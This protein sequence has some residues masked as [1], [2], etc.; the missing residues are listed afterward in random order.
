MMRR[1]GHVRGVSSIDGKVSV[2]GCC[3]RGAWR[4]SI[5]LIVFLEKGG[6]LGRHFTSRRVVV[7]G[8]HIGFVFFLGMISYI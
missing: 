5:L 1:P 4:P 7:S 6:D 3:R 2:L 8:L